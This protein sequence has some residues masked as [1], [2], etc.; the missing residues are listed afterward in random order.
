MSLSV[1]KFLRRAHLS[2][3]TDDVLAKVRFFLRCFSEA[4]V[5]T[6]VD[7]SRQYIRADLGITFSASAALPMMPLTQ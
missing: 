3:W 5:N 7:V 2:L 1:E 4:V 6:A